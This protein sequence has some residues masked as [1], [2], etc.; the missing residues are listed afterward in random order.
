MKNLRP[1]DTIQKFL[2]ST[3]SRF[4][5]EFE[6][7]NF[8]IAHAWPNLRKIPSQISM[9]EN[10]IC[11]NAFVVAFETEQI[12]EQR[13]V[14]PDYSHVPNLICVYLSI[15]FGKRFDSHGPI[16]H[17]GMY[18][19]PHFE[20]SSFCYPQL[21]FNSHKPRVDLGIE[22]DLGETARI[23]KLLENNID[24]KASKF[25]RSAG[26]FYLQA[27]QTFE[28]NPETAYLNLITCGEIL[29]N[30]YE[31]DKNELLDREAISFLR[32]IE[33]ELD[34]GQKISN[35]IK[36]RLL[37]VKK[38]FSKKICNLLTDLFFENTESLQP[39][40][41]LKKENIKDRIDAAYDLRSRYVHTGIDFGNW[42]SYTSTNAE[43][44]TGT[45]VVKDREFKNILAK[46]PTFI[47]LER[48]MRFCLLR[49]LQLQ[50]IPVDQRLMEP[51]AEQG[52]TH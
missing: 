42:V 39:F 40:T 47:G 1:K 50:G 5:G 13:V 14:L 46:A 19:L 43:I 2:I 7:E 32:V 38:K 22:L 4:T 52:A 37:Q 45:P 35:Q 15:L 33:T 12:E 23:E 8:V 41:A 21:P 34:N 11:R 31:H 24:N 25:F 3:T 20:Y 10:P 51:K 17:I 36:N 49:F 48:I 27:L 16:E 9:T 30:F 44:Q 26:K 29:S 18:G 6:I 28:N